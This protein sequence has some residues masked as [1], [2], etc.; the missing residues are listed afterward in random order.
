MGTTLATGCVL[1]ASMLV[2]SAI[3]HRV[4]MHEILIAL[5][6]VITSP[7]TAMTLMRAAMYRTQLH[8]ATQGD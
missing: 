4:V 2:S 8:S 3:L 5:F 7:I 6:I 1:I